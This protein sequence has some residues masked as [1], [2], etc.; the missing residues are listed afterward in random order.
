[1]ACRYVARVYSYI[2]QQPIS[3]LFLWLTAFFISPCQAQFTDTLQYNQRHFNDENGLPQNSV[4]SIVPGE[5]G[6]IWLATENGLVRFDGYNFITYNKDNIGFESSRLYY[7]IPSGMPYSYFAVTANEQLAF[8]QKGKATLVNNTTEQQNIYLQGHLQHISHLDRYT[9]IGL[10]NLYKDGISFTSYTIPLDKT[11]WFDIDSGNVALVANNHPHQLARLPGASP[12]NFFLLDRRLYYYSR[13]GALLLDTVLQPSTVAFKKIDVTGD[14]LQN[15]AWRTRNKPER[16]YWNTASRQVFFYINQSLYRVI[17]RS[18]GSLHTSCILNQFNL[19]VNKVACVYFDEAQQQL[20]LGSVTNGL[21]VFKRKQFIPVQVRKEGQEV[22]YAQLAFGNDK[23]ITPWG[24]ILS[25]FF[26]KK[27]ISKIVYKATAGVDHYSMA[28]DMSQNI[29][30]KSA[31][32]LFRFDSSA[33][34]LTG[35]WYYSDDIHQ[36]YA[37]STGALWV[38]FRNRG[39]YVVPAEK[40]DP[41]LFLP[42]IK[43]ITCMYRNGNILWLGTGAAL[44]RISIAER[45]MDTISQFNGKYIRSLYVPN[46]DEVWITTHDEGFFLYKAGHITRF[47]PDKNN[48]LATSHCLVEDKRGY[49][50]I[51]TNKGLFQAARQD[52]MDYANGMR[53]DVFYLYYTRENGFNTNEFNG[54]CM[55]CAVKLNNGYISLPSLSGLVWFHPDSLQFDLPDKEL[56]ID[57][58]EIDQEQVPVKDT[59]QLP[60]DFQQLKLYVATPYYGNENNVRIEYGFKVGAR[61]PEWLRV[62]DNQSILLSALNAGHHQLII[63][64]CNGFG[65]DNYSSRTLVF[66][67]APAYYETWWFAMALLVLVILAIWGYSA[68]RV[69]YVR[70]KNKLLEQSIAERTGELEQTLKALQVSEEQLR[71]QT[72]IHERLITAMA[73]DIKSPLKYMTDAALSMVKRSD[74]QSGVEEIKKQ[75]QLLFDSGTRIYY[76]TDNLLQYIKLY[77]RQGIIAMEPVNLYHVVDE[78]VR[79]FWEIAGQQSTTL[80]NQVAS[81]VQVHSNGRLLGVIIHNIIDNAVKVTLNGTITITTKAK[82][83]EL[84]IIVSDTGPGMAEELVAWCNTDTTGSSQHNGHRDLPEYMGMGLLIVKELLVLVNGRL[85]VDSKPQVGTSVH[86]I[87]QNSH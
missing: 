45:R 74:S 59:I 29:W 71:K 34:E 62:P 79:I 75:A 11:T 76:F 41:G 80:Q 57:K 9:T 83:Q 25:P 49:F 12:W 51:T 36:L 17:P 15:K 2:A 20:F 73:H 85:H 26:A 18:D 46:P 50:W 84:H 69:Q 55:P 38:G 4:K 53:R 7:I 32:R 52:L 16:I 23:V 5:G 86:I 68:I 39:L 56:F 35:Q 65:R 60:R 27:E 19:P 8:I 82:Q 6:F 22:Y 14:V 13:R 37:D 77:A 54:G 3:A 42:A 31:Q 44:Y 43:N 63:R 1:M 28:R 87:I 78:K 61:E 40:N 67:V 30:I 66:I 24:R 64:K 33:S 70:R 81:D 48:Y 47:P 21:F 10:P 58:L 72:R